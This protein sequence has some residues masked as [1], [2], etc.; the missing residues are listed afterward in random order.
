MRAAW[1]ITVLLALTVAAQ[2]GVFSEKE[3]AAARKLNLTK[4]AKC[5]KLYDPANYTEQAWS[6]WLARMNGKARLN[7]DQADSLARYFDT[8]RAVTKA[9]STNGLARR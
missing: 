5:H 6:D 1:F 3:Q 9:S 8:L 2:A 4:C 7:S